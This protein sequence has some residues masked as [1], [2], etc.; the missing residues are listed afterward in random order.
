MGAPG[1]FDSVIDLSAI[2]AGTVIRIELQ[3]LSMADG[4]MLAMDSVELVVK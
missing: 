4:H 2:P 1:T 3:D